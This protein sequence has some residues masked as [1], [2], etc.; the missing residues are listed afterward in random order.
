MKKEA[1]STMD[2]IHMTNFMDLK[3]L[4]S[5]VRFCTVWCSSGHH[6]QEGCTSSKLS[7]NEQVYLR[8][9]AAYYGT[10][11]DHNVYLIEYKWVANGA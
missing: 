6:S 8:P 11:F 10:H 4:M 1:Q 5:S 7:Q 9:N 2:V 3:W